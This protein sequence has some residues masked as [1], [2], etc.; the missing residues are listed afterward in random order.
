[1]CSS[2]TGLLREGRR[3]AVGHRLRNEPGPPRLFSGSLAFLA[4]PSAV[5]AVGTAEAVG[6][7]AGSSPLGTDR[8]LRASTTSPAF[9]QVLQ[10]GLR[11]HF[12]TSGSGGLKC[13]GG[14]KGGEGLRLAGGRS[15]AAP[16]GRSAAAFRSSRDGLRPFDRRD[17][18][19]VTA[20]REWRAFEG[21]A[22]PAVAGV[23]PSAADPG[24]ARTAIQGA[25]G[26]LFR[27]GGRAGAAPVRR[28]NSDDGRQSTPDSHSAGSSAR[29]KA[30]PPPALQ[31][32]LWLRRIF[33][34]G[35]VSSRFGAQRGGDS[36]GPRGRAAA[37]PPSG[38]GGVVVGTRENDPTRT[39]ATAAG[40]FPRPTNRAPGR[41]RRPAAKG[42]RRPSRRRAPRQDDGQAAPRGWGRG[43]RFPR[44]R[45]PGEGPAPA[46][47]GKREGREVGK[48]VPSGHDTVGGRVRSRGRASP[49]DETAR[50]GRTTPRPGQ[51]PT[52]IRL[53]PRGDGR[54]EPAEA[55]TSSPER[56]WREP[57]VCRVLLL[58]RLLSRRHGP[59]S[60]GL[61][62]G[63]VDSRGDL[64][65]SRRIAL[66]YFSS[67]PDD[68]V[69]FLFARCA[70]SAGMTSP[71]KRKRVLE[72]DR[73]G[74]LFPKRGRR[75]GMQAADQSAWRYPLGLGFGRRGLLYRTCHT[76][77]I[78]DATINC[79][80]WGT[81]EDHG[82]AKRETLV[83]RVERPIAQREAK[84]SVVALQLLRP[85]GWF[86]GEYG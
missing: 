17:R 12:R 32:R 7:L 27:A 11:G 40:E 15:A 20:R 65:S 24:E 18:P 35:R 63:H 56:E 4:L 9:L 86:K 3:A 1:M 51:P 5:A 82:T 13:D 16:E 75:R 81:R 58:T 74:G 44:R 34:D 49:V 66:S 36:P 25:G 8:R 19:A 71:G 47:F 77:R 39:P 14:A 73:A 54:D 50:T 59:R 52:S 38:S 43:R 10:A 61:K 42:R 80:K 84:P 85:D 41:T 30:L 21:R 72:P 53:P 31:S 2:I 62:R 29:W 28:P 23:P 26:E 68:W 33:Q 64:Q 22:A 46:A 37:F 70:A 67:I 79:L 45:L 48:R 76:P 69:D 60:E 6:R 83:G 78:A 55:P 57:R